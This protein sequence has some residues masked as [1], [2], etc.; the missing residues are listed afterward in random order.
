M[1]TG[2]HPSLIHLL[3]SKITS[4][5]FTKI[6][7]DLG[8]G[9]RY[10]KQFVERLPLPNFLSN[11]DFYNNLTESNIDI[12]LKNYYQFSKIEAKIIG[13]F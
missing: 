6:S 5:Y 2:M 1:I 8:N 10:F 7:S 12:Q 9:S 11:K 4:W 13:L 3:N